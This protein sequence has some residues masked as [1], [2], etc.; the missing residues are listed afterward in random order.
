[1]PELSPGK[2]YLEVNI[3]P[4]DEPQID[5]DGNQA[6]FVKFRPDDTDLLWVDPSRL[7]PVPAE[8]EIEFGV[9]YLSGNDGRYPMP[10]ERAARELAAED[11]ERRT[12]VVRREVR[13]GPWVDVPIEEKP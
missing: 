9:R 5:E 8:P 3:S 13:R 7:H 4:M 2:Y 10:G 1:M 12:V 11:A 6:V